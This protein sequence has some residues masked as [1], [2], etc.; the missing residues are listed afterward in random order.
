MFRKLKIHKSLIAMAH[1]TKFFISFLQILTKMASLRIIPPLLCFLF[2]FG[3]HV[4][5][6]PVANDAPENE[7]SWL[8][9]WLKCFINDASEDVGH[10]FLTR[11]INCCPLT[12]LMT[13]STTSDCKLKYKKTSGHFNYPVIKILLLWG[14]SIGDL[15]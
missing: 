8:K 15:L 10:F 2:L 13:T 12:T 5:A 3:I 9:Q 11:L 7:S 6:N 1:S 4:N 14:S